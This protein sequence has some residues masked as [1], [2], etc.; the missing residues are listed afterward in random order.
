MQG[1]KCKDLYG[2]NGFSLPALP[3]PFEDCLATRDRTH[4]WSP[5]CPLTNRRSLSDLLTVWMTRVANKPYSMA[6]KANVC[7]V[8]W[9]LIPSQCTSGSNEEDEWVAKVSSE[10]YVEFRGGDRSLGSEF[11]FFYFGDS[12][13]RL[14]LGAQPWERI[15][16]RKGRGTKNMN[17]LNGS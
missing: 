1:Q 16:R 8:W 7:R 3:K 11:I 12:V 14:R 6:L 17:H 15:H 10:I 5:L 2:E 13:R 9:P 4:D